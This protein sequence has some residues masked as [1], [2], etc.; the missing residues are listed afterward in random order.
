MLI[1]IHTRTRVILVGTSLLAYALVFVPLYRIAGAG[2]AALS[3]VPVAVIGW[4]LGRWAG[5][6]GGALL[7][8]LDTV[9]FNLAGVPGWDAVLRV[10]GG[11]GSAALLLI[12]TSTGWLSTLVERDR[13]Q[14]AELI[15]ER[16]ALKQAVE[17]ARAHE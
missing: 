9:L 6:L 14:T 1:S 5:L 3:V 2:I 4:C 8:A 16:E 15:R 10:G 12:G 7:I 17:R 13:R 11:P